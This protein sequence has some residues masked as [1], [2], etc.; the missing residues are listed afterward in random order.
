[1]PDERGRLR[2]H[3]PMSSRRPPPPEGNQDTVDTSQDS[4]IGKLS[5]EKV[6]LYD[7]LQTTTEPDRRQE[8]QRRIN[9]IEGRLKELGDF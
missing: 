2:P 5:R 6:Q 3:E 1:M 7:T 4:E 9:E 8:I